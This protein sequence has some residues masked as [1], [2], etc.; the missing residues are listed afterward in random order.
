M[1]FASRRHML[2]ARR[3]LF[4]A[5]LW[6]GAVSSLGAQDTSATPTLFG[7]YHNASPRNAQASIERAL[8]DAANRVGSVLRGQIRSRLR[9]WNQV[10]MTL[11]IARESNVLVLTLDDVRYAA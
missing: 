7:R 8:W 3:I 10:P 6:L 9:L 1:C 4:I 2:Q 5:L 11:E